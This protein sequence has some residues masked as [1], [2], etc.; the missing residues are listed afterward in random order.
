MYSPQKVGR[1][2]S[3]FNNPLA[4]L[5]YVSVCN[6]VNGDIIKAYNAAKCYRCGIPYEDLIKTSR[7]V[8]ERQ[9]LINKKRATIRLKIKRREAAK[10]VSPI[11]EEIKPKR[12]GKAKVKAKIN[13]M[14]SHVKQMIKR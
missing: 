14:F 13:I 8:A 11:K 5:Q 4:S 1:Y 10:N 12:T 9:E 6:S 2:Y 7:F 3:C